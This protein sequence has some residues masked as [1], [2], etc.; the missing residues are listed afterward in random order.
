MSPLPVLLHERL[1]CLP[2][3]LSCHPA[4]PDHVGEMRALIA[5]EVEESL[6]NAPAEVRG[7]MTGMRLDEWRSGLRRRRPGA[8]PLILLGREG[9]AG[10]MV[11]DW[12][13]SGPI[14]LLD[15]VIHPALRNGGL[16]GQV[17]AGLCAL[18]GQ[19]GRPLRIT[20]LYNNPARRLLA[21]HG[22]RPVQESG[23]DVVLER[24]AG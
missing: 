14:L 1:S 18:A 5:A 10:G 4:M 8:T 7:M 19:A 12:T 17:I 3:P 23:V 2:R 22:F 15:G 20:L 11:L 13:G 6:A 16:G 24:A 21:R 9:V